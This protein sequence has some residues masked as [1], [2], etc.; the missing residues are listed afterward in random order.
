M[1]LGNQVEAELEVGIQFM[2]LFIFRWINEG[3]NGIGWN[4]I[5]IETQE[6]KAF[7]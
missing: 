5:I 2:V 4:G 7:E 3:V 6:I 1:D